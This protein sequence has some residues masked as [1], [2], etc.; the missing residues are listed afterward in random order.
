MSSENVSDKS[1][2]VALA[3]ATIIGPFGAHR[4]YVGKVGTGILQLCTIG[5]F[6]IWWLYDWILVLA[7]GFRDSNDR[8]LVKWLE[9]ESLSFRS[10]PETAEKLEM[11]LDEVYNLREEMG[12]F[13]ERVDFMERMLSRASERDQ[14]PP[15]SARP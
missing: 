8:R 3:L 14:I 1:R 6:G 4:F 11:L 9:D 13:G 2:G 5:G 7:G 10:D 12:E 15:P